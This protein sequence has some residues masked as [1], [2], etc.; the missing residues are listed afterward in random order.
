MPILKYASRKRTLLLLIFAA[1]QSVTNAAIAVAADDTLQLVYHACLINDNQKA[2]AL[3]EPYVHGSGAESSQAHL[4]YGRVLFRLKRIPEARAEFEKVIKMGSFADATEAKASLSEIREPQ[5]IA[6]SITKGGRRGYVGLLMEGSLVKDVLPSSPAAFAKIMSG[7]KITEIDRR[8]TAHMTTEDI[9]KFIHGPIGTTVTLTVERK[10]KLYTCPIKR[11]EVEE[12]VGRSGRTLDFTQSSQTS[13]DRASQHSVRSASEAMQSSKQVKKAD[14]SA[15]T[16]ISPTDR[17]LVTIHRKSGD[18]TPVYDQVAQCLQKVRPS[19]KKELLDWGLKIE[20]VPNI[21]EARPELKGNKPRGY[22]HGGD[23]NNC[24]GLF[25]PADKTILVAE[26]ASIGSSPYQR[27]VWVASTMLHE[28]GHAV[29]YMKLA[30]NSE[31]FKTAYDEDNHRL[32][33]ELRNEFYYYTQNDAG[34]PE[35]FAQLFAINLG[36]PESDAAEM[37]IAFPRTW[38]LVQNDYLNRF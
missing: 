36:A 6:S 12:T 29:D 35:L 7:D 21:L 24:P 3:I 19:L 20:I 14:G 30:T 28:M 4:W 2:L 25:M 10:G 37:K 34:G 5:S 11:A 31:E 38:K 17:A 13:A 27:N 18:S 9:V 33:N 8:S 1:A 26:K 16:D 32:T 15:V 23:Y 22:I